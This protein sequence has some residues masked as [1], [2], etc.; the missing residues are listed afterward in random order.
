MGSGRWDSDTWA[1]TRSSYTKEAAPTVDHIYKSKT[2]DKN[3]DPKGITLRESRDSDANPNST[4][5]IVGLDVT[6]SMSRVL[7]VMAREGLGTLVEQI[8]DREPITDPHI[9]I[10]GIGDVEH[11]EAPL[12]V[13]QF[14]AQNQPLV[15]QM[16]NI[17]LERGGGGNDYESYSAAWLFAATRTSIDC[18]EKRGK[19][20]YLFTVGDEEPTPMLSPKNVG[21][22]LNIDFLDEEDLTGQA[23]FELVS[24][25]YDV[26]H[27]MVA[28][29]SHARSRPDQVREAWGNLIGQKL[30]ILPDHTKL[31]EV[32]VS[33]IQLAEGVNKDA[34]I[35][36]WSGDTSLIVAE[37]IKDITPSETLAKGT[38]IGGPELGY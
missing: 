4:P 27:V 16:E 10:M 23:L 8:Y 9:M 14:E 37:A 32:I 2:L 34:V 28:E 33:A 19:K 25:M 36:S 6:G 13:T 17:W 18:F 11:D 29:G 20:G 21:R 22:F 12:Q 5:L 35:S 24:A 7:D 38:P 30:I 31:A 15:A 1:T 3:L 26:Y